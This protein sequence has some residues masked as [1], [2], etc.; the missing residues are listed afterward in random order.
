AR[1]NNPPGASLAELQELER[2]YVLPTYKRFP[3]QFVRGEGC[4][5]WDDEGNEYLDMLAGISVCNVGHCH[6]AVVAAVR[7]QAGRLTHTTNLYYTEPAMRLAE[8]L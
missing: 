2:E 4:R 1:A 3:V 7:E 5:L 6:P 8:R